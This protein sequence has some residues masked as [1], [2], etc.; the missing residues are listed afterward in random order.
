MVLRYSQFTIKIEN[1]IK[2]ELSLTFSL[3]GIRVDDE[4]SVA[5]NIRARWFFYPDQDYPRVHL[6]GSFN[7]DSDVW[8]IIAH[9]DVLP[10]N[11]GNRSQ[12]S[13][14]KAKLRYPDPD[15]LTKKEIMLP[16]A[17]SILNEFLVAGFK[18][19]GT[20]SHCNTR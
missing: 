15:A 2:T 7:E 4:S 1:I 16:L 17:K 5:P 19:S 3:F 9:I 12:E 10:H 14:E 20:I 13:L 6:F 8:E 18:A 11:S